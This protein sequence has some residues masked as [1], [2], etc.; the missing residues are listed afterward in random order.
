M[1]MLFDTQKKEVTR[2]NDRITA[3]QLDLNE[4]STE[5]TDLKHSSYELY[6]ISKEDIK[7]I[8]ASINTNKEKT[9]S[10]NA[11]YKELISKLS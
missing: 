9:I 2:L 11:E 6:D 7:R 4:K 5:I 10:N 3:F 1:K 8:E